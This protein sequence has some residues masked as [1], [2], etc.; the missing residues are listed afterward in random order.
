[1]SLC[2]L[3]A[4]PIQTGKMMVVVNET[5]NRL[6]SEWGRRRAILLLC[7]SPREIIDE[8]HISHK[9]T[10][11]LEYESQYR[12]PSVVDVDGPSGT[13]QASRENERCLRV[14]Y[15]Y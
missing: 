13:R 7:R 6:R 5:R 1:M 14:E 12:F 15:F 9:H 11:P 10:R 2:F 3:H 4:P 8:T